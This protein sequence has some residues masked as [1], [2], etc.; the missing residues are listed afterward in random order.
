MTAP[1]S[2]VAAVVLNWN[3]RALTERCLA[4]LLA[5]GGP[6]RVVVVDNGSRGGEGEAL[7][8]A[9]AS[10]PRVEV[11][12]LPR[13]LGFA[14]GVNEGVRRAVAGGASEV[15]LLNNDALLEPGALEALRAALASGREVAAAGPLVLLD[16]GSGRAWFAGGRV[17]PAFGQVLH[18]GYGKRPGDLPRATRP[19]GFLSFCAVL[20]CAGAWAQVGPLDEEFFAYGEDA[21]WSLRARRAGRTLVHCPAACMSGATGRKTAPWPSGAMRSTISSGVVIGPRRRAG[22][23]PPMQEWKASSWRQTTPFG[24]PV[25]PP[26]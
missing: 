19:V 16:D 24:I 2:P 20:L 11:A 17:V 13:N 26:V 8:A 21:D 3:G 22:S 23:P 5:P 25:V 12:L 6:G 4:S 10:E 14:G 1:A 18:P 15:L 7:R 9:Y